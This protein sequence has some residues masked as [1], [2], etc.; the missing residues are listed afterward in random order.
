MN[1]LPD[2]KVLVTTSGTQGPWGG[3]GQYELSYATKWDCKLVQ[4]LAVYQHLNVHS[5]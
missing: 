4:I 3:V 1:G 2:F 5:K